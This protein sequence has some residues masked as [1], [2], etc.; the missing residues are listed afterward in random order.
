MGKRVVCV[1]IMIFMLAFLTPARSHAEE[2]PEKYRTE[3]ATEVEAQGG[4]ML[5]WAFAGVAA[6]EIELIK[7]NGADPNLDLSEVQ[8]AYF[9][10]N[11]VMDELGLTNVLFSGNYRPNKGGTFNE[12]ASVIASGLSPVEES[13]V[14]VSIEEFSNETKLDESLAKTDKYYLKECVSLYG[15]S[16]D[17]IKRTIMQ[18]GAVGMD[19]Y[20]S[21][22]NYNSKTYGQYTPYNMNTNHA[23]CIVGWDDTYSKENFLTTP[24][25]DGAWIAKNSYGKGW[26]DNG[27]FYLSYYD[28][29]IVE[30]VNMAFD[31]ENGQ[32]SDNVY[33]YCNNI[34]SGKSYNM[35]GE[36]FY[37]NYPDAEKVANIFTAQANDEGAELLKAVSFYTHEPVEYVINIYKNLKKTANPESGTL[38]A[39]LEGEFTTGGYRI[40]PLDKAVYLSEG[41]MFSIVAQLKNSEGEY[42]GTA[43][44][45]Y[46]ESTLVTYGQSFVC[47][48]GRWRDARHILKTW[49]L[50][51]FTDN[52]EK[53]VKAD[54]NKVSTDKSVPIVGIMGADDV[55][56]VVVT[57]VD[58]ET[59]S[60]SWNK[61]PG[62]G[63]VIYQY[64]KI[65]DTWKRIG[66]SEKN[67]Y[68]VTGLLPKQEYTFGVKAIKQGE[69]SYTS[70]Y[71]YDSLNFAEAEAKTAE[72]SR[73]ML[74]VETDSK[75]NALAWT[76]TTGATKYE[77]YV[78]S[79]L[80]EYEWVKLENVSA[81]DSLKYTDTAVKG[82]LTYAYR[83]Y[84]YRN[85]E[86][87]S[88]SRPVSIIYK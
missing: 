70:M 47:E 9:R 88:K 12:L 75:G 80:T 27:Y 4:S 16:V 41:E 7:N 52:I 73:A 14:P 85:D 38:A 42:V 87:I 23:V 57:G 45:G 78:L 54:A 13:L 25:G 49:F 11:P 18:Y 83:I 59:V 32:Y 39:T 76:K 40:I 33:Q 63:Y 29:T 20:I 62:N 79:P 21:N 81:S 56:E 37:G 69:Y 86:L 10:A 46:Y 67:Y 34:N 58:G 30:S 44:N 1:A 60:L 68:T 2:L 17:E 82:G 72:F 22:D 84:S 19:Y 77:V 50:E 24:E 5:C 3:E 35:Q 64:N 66:C 15:A 8:L 6:M 48:K 65:A 31:L 74:Q 28:K 26:G 71:Y 43:E 51:A 53:D 55:E 61:V 36:T